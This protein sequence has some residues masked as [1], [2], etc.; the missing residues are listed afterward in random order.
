MRLELMRD[1]NGNLIQVLPP[2]NYRDCR[3]LAADTHETYTV[4][5]GYKYALITASLDT[6][7]QGNSTSFALPTDV[8]DGTCPMMVPA[9]GSR[10]MALDGITDLGF[11]AVGAPRVILEY[12]KR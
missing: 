8:T 5:T 2:S 1:S 9:G 4:P 12:F 10:L 7:V 11:R 6:F 3:T